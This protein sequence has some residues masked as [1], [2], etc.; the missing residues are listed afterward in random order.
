[1]SYS[2]SYNVD[3]G[4]SSTFSLSYMIILLVISILIL[5][6]TW[7]VFE[8]AGE[9]GWKCLIPFYNTY[10]QTKIATGNGWLFL[11]YLIPLVGGFFG[12]YVMYKLAQAFN[13]GFGFT[14]GLIFLPVIFYPMLG[15][16]NAEYYG[17]Q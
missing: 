14:L 12:I 6:G 8:K 17:Q 13:K 7:K 15:F 4:F 1:M 3:P 11:V 5:A 9:S 10:I 2:Y 16:G